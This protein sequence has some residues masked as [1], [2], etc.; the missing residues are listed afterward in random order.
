MLVLSL[1]LACIKRRS[2]FFFPLIEV[3]LIC[4]VVLILFFF[5]QV[6]LEF[7]TILL[8]FHVLG[9]GP[10]VPWDS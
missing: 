10:E 6:F 9:F 8:L 1:G 2:F 4:N 3:Q 7:V 5:P